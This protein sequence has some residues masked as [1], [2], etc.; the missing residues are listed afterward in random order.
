MISSFSFHCSVYSLVF[1]KQDFDGGSIGQTV[2]EAFQNNTGL[3]SQL[4]WQVIDASQFSNVDEVAAAVVDEQVWVAV[5]SKFLIINF[6]FPFPF[7]ASF[8]LP[9]TFSSSSLPS[10]LP[11]L[12]LTPLIPGLYNS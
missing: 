2:V 7:L 10:V 3:P 12:N 4:T 11:F 1:T 9:R 6:V 5:T 8:P